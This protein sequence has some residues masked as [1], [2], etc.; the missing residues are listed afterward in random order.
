MMQ[1]PRGEGHC[2]L[3][4]DRRIEYNNSSARPYLSR[5]D[6]VDTTR[7]FIDRSTQVDDYGPL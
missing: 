7:D 6:D 1:L 4:M 3:V 2:R 5:D